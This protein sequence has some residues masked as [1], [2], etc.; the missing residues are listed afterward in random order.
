MPPHASP[1]THSTSALEQFACP[2]TTQ[3][4]FTSQRGKRV[5]HNVATLAKDP[6]K[7]PSAAALRAGAA[8]THATHALAA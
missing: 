4:T 1:D 6:D 3:A 2:C 5:T 7:S 8:V